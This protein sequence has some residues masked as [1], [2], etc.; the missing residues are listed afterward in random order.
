[1]PTAV[2][3]ESTENTM[4]MMMICTMMAENAAPAVLLEAA[5]MRLL[6]LGMHLV[7]RL[8]DEEQ[9]ARDQDDVLPRVA[10]AEQLE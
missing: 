5:V 1:M 6:D 7:R 2:M 3:I 10:D 9:A 4:S 8:V